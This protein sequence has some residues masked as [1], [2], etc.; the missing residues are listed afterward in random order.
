LLASIERFLKQRCKRRTI[1][2]LEGQY[3]GPKKLKAS[4]KAA[5][6]KKKKLAKKAAAAK[7][8]KKR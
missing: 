3:T 1:Q 5:G 2:G 7:K 4:G 6:S 8:G